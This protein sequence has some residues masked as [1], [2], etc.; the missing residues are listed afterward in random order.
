[1]MISSF[2]RRR[3]YNA[4]GFER[5]VSGR[6]AF[7]K[8]G[9]VCAREVLALRSHRRDWA[10]LIEMC[11]RGSTPFWFDQE[12]SMRQGTARRLLLGLKGAS[13]DELDL[14][15]QRSLSGRATRSAH[16]RVGCGGRPS[17]SLRPAT[18]MRKIRNRRVQE[19][20]KLVFD[21]VEELGSAPT[22]ALLVPRVQPRSAGERP[23]ATRP[24][25]DRVTA[26]ITGSLDRLTAA[27]NAMVRTAAARDTPP[28]A[29]SV[30]IRR[31]RRNEWL[32]LKPNTARRVCSWERVRGDPRNG[33][34][35]TLPLVDSR[36]TAKH[37]IRC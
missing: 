20:I 24:G 22:G 6:F 25:G 16:G 31:K 29:V 3:R 14:L 2:S 8:V 36:R 33:S 1:M 18:V 35:A 37:G 26:T 30:K 11:R 10:A 34:A 9:A 21:K 23:T 19:A 4:P 13:R 17:A 15:R 7:G 27:P 5:M 32:T 28:R 12:P